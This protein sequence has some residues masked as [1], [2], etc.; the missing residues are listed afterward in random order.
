MGRLKIAN[1]AKSTDASVW[2]KPFQTIMG[3]KCVVT[4]V[5]A[6]DRHVM[7]QIKFQKIGERNASRAVISG[8][9][10]FEVSFCE[11]SLLVFWSGAPSAA[12]PMLSGERFIPT[13]NGRPATRNSTPAKNAAQRHPNVWCKRGQVRCLL[14]VNASSILRILR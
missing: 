2:L 14:F 3:M 10:L 12:M 8:S 7:E 5:N 13:H 11:P 9:W 6:T 1:A 4:V